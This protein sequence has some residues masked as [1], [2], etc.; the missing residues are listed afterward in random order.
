LAM[1][2]H[3]R[4]SHALKPVAYFV[5]LLPSALLTLSE[6]GLASTR[7]QLSFNL[8]TPFALAV[9]CVYFYQVQL[10]P[11]DFRK[12]LVV[13]LAPI[14][15]IAAGCLFGILSAEH[16]EFTTQSNFDT[17]GGYGPNQV[18]SVLGLGMLAAFLAYGLRRSST[19][20]MILYLVVVVFLA[21]MS[22][23]TFSR[24][25]LCIG[26]GSTMAAMFFLSRNRRALASMLFG[27]ATI[28][29][30][31][32]FVI[33]PLLS[34]FTGGK[35]SE[36]FQKK[37]FSHRDELA[38]TDLQIWLLHPIAGVG[39]GMVKAARVRNFGM[40]GMA[41]TEFTRLFAEHGLF[42][43]LALVVLLSMALKNFS[44]AAGPVPK[45]VVSGFLVFSFL[46]MM[47]TAMRL[48]AP[49]FAFGLTCAKLAVSRGGISRASPHSCRSRFRLNFAVPTWRR[50]SPGNQYRKAAQARCRQDA[51]GK[52]QADA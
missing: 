22:A 18:S 43:A 31:A 1:V 4:V 9:T 50:R 11:V 24:S 36:R 32:W 10:T 8:S 37:G 44:S 47:A 34:D 12:L 30:I 46:F 45:A 25:G 41:H 14:I 6:V 3:R 35:L 2:R 42:G 26:A 49:A 33:F 16:I 20:E 39:P 7:A 19:L 23:L 40:A 17:S 28:I 29:G 21:S 5:L 48:V 13:L 51:E 38:Q 52:D 27:A 15:A